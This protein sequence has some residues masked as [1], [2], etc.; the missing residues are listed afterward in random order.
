MTGDGVTVAAK[1]LDDVGGDPGSGDVIC[2]ESMATLFL[3]DFPL[4]DERTY[5]LEWMRQIEEGK[6]RPSLV[7][8]REMTD[9]QHS[10][11]Q[12]SHTP[13]AI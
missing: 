2:A 1:L 7:V 8:S 10:P 11:D 4:S 12:G 3:E 9:R 6:P 13:L 5:C